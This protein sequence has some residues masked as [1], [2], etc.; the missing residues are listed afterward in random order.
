MR[1]RM[2]AYAFTTRR[3]ARDDHSFWYMSL[4]G[5]F[6]VLN[7][8]CVI[9]ENDTVSSHSMRVVSPR[10]TFRRARR[11][12]RRLARRTTSCQY[13]TTSPKRK[14]ILQGFPWEVLRRSTSAFVITIGHC[15]YALA[16]VDMGQ[17]WKRGR[18]SAPRPT[19][20]PI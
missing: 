19:L 7:R 15:R 13:S 5:T 20:S 2:M 9:S 16:D 14:L 6:E 17:S 4:P 1:Q 12:I 11:L 3:P 10:P 8:S 18:P